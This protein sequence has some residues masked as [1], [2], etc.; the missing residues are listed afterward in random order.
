[1]EKLWSYDFSSIFCEFLKFEKYAPLWFTAELQG[2]WAESVCDVSRGRHFA[3]RDDVE[4]EETADQR[5]QRDCS[6]ENIYYNALY[7][8]CYELPYTTYLPL[9]IKQRFRGNTTGQ[10]GTDS[11][12]SFS[13]IRLDWKLLS[14][15]RSVIIFYR[16]CDHISYLPSG[17][18]EYSP[19]ELK[20]CVISQCFGCQPLWLSSCLLARDK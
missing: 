10:V 19:A 3:W 7:V 17:T 18:S 14:N 11:S 15:D 12:N 2:E 13:G 16:S 8:C 5:S 1:M 20:T 4:G 9:A 6:E